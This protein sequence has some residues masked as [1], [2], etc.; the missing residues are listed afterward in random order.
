V[1]YPDV[2][3]TCG[4]AL[5]GDEQFVMNRTLVIEVLLPR[6]TGYDKRDKLLLYRTLA[7]LREFVLVDAATRQVEVFTRAEEGV[8]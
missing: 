2:M 4:K 1:L 8:W 6:A 7:S 3:V 5:A